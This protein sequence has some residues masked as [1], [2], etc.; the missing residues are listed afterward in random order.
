MARR[1][2]TTA[3]FSAWRCRRVRGSIARGKC[4]IFG[5]LSPIFR[6]FGLVYGSI[7]A[8]RYVRHHTRGK[9]PTYTDRA[10]E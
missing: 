10:L 8:K 9:R 6:S 7:Q 5:R 3:C 2:A 4:D 1:S